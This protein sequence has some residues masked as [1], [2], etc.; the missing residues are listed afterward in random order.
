MSSTNGTADGEKKMNTQEQEAPAAAPDIVPAHAHA[1]AA[2]EQ[3]ESPGGLRTVGALLG[4]ALLIAIAY[5]LH[6]R[7]ADEKT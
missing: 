3:V 6:I 4:I 1:P 2:D 7:S 5:G